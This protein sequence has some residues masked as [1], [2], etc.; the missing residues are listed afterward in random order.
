MEYEQKRHEAV[1]FFAGPLDVERRAFLAA[2][3]IRYVVLGPV[4]RM[5]AAPEWSGAAQAGLVT[6]YD[7]DEVTIFAVAQP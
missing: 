4:E 7:A 2:H 5:T 6:I 3:G 1:W